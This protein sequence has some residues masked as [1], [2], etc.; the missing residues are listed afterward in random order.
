MD[1][2]QLQYFVTIVE[3]GQITKA[4]KKLHMAQ[5]PL[6]HQLKLIELE[7]GCKLFDRHGR[8]IY[9][10]ESGSILYEKAK[11]LLSLFEDSMFEVKEVGKGVKGLLSIG[12]DPTCQSYVIDKIISMNKQY[13]NIQYKLIEGDTLVLTEK[14]EQKDI[15]IAIIQ[16]PIEDDRF[17][18]ISLEPDPYVLVAP[19]N[20]NLKGPIKVNSIKELPFLSFFRN[21]KCNTFKM[22]NDEFRKHGFTPNIVCDCIDLAMIVSLIKEGLGVTILPRTSLNR[23]DKDGLKIL[24]FVNL[25][26]Q[27]KAM[28]I[29]HNNR[30]LSKNVR[31]FIHLFTEN[32]TA[33]DKIY[34]SL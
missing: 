10:T 22:I 4:A 19:E 7:L 13:P 9:L 16:S 34:I 28:V 29:W 15:D 18:S 8:N 24:E 33:P 30:Y 11:S 2:R 3:E 26:I 31:N 27:S 1:L 17:E 12:I 25:G 6:S 23:F 32:K 21:R 5:P 20:Y 14:L